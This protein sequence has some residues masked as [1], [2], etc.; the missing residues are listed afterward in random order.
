M[1]WD[2]IA[3]TMAGI[4]GA[5]A[6]LLGEWNVLLTILAV[7]MVLD[8]ATGVIVA[9][10]GKSPKTKTGGVSSSVSFDGLIKKAFIMVVVLIATLLDTAIG[11][12]TRV[13]QM[14]ATMYY[15]ANEGISVL[16]NTALMG[17][18]YPRFIMKAL[19][20]MREKNDSLDHGNVVREAG[21]FSDKT[22]IS[23]ADS[24]NSADETGTFDNDSGI[25]DDNTSAF[26]DDSDIAINHLLHRKDK[27]PGEGDGE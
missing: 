26:A 7:M 11:N 22:G 21:E 27:P 23:D 1:K 20:A 15:I 24:D 12:T 14:A 4:A 5:I 19:E 3:K 13:F 2:D 18:V 6:G 17:V 9:W 16:E 25:S 8:Y 10:R